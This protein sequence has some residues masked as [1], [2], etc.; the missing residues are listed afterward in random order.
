MKKAASFL[1]IALVLIA[2]ISF[3]IFPKSSTSFTVLDNFEGDIKVYKSMTCGCCELHAKY[4]DSKGSFDVDRIDVQ[5]VSVIKDQ[6]EIPNALR[7]CHTTV[8]GDYFVE[9]H[10]PIEAVNK[11]LE[12]KPD[13]AGIAMPNMPS[14]SPGMPGAKY[15]DFVIYAVK[16]D[17]SF[18]EFMRI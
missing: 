10:I 9:G 2:V 4:I 5:D 17:G 14:G 3:L 8:I 12:E 1:L 13:I 11:L 6:Y 7:S 15:G 18:Y 16:H